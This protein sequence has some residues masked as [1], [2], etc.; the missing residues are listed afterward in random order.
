MRTEEEL[1]ELAKRVIKNEVFMA[2][3]EESISNAFMLLVSLGAEFPPG[4]VALYEEY[5]KALPRSI[6]GFPMFSS[7]GCLSKEEFDIFVEYYTKF[8]ELLNS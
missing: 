3:N 8:N 4:T 6:N 5:S 7:C 2:S 1:K